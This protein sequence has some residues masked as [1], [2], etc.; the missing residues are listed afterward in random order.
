MCNNKSLLTLN[1]PMFCRKKNIGQY[2][3]AELTNED[4]IK[5]GIDNSEIRQKLIEEVKN[6]PVY[7]EV[8]TQM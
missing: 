2:T 3:L 4:L 7:E 6:L 8:S 1:I 5:L